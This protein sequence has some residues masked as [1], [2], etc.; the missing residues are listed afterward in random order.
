MRT[1][2]WV[3]AISV[4]SSTAHAQLEW[5]PETPGAPAIDT[6]LRAALRGGTE[7]VRGRARTVSDV[8]LL[9]TVG[10]AIGDAIVDPLS[11]DDPD[12]LAPSLFFGIGA[13]ALTWTLGELVKHATVRARPYTLACAETPFAC[14]ARAATLSFY[15]LHAALAAT[16]AAL[17]C[18]RRSALGDAWDTGLCI[19][20]IGSAAAVALLRIIGDMHHTTDVVVGALLGIASGLAFGAL[21]SSSDLR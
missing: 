13:L 7:D 21:V 11:H 18:A 17:V 14:D 20:S 19:G 8:L 1:A 5:E 10:V 12:A 3:I 6:T 2:V 16:S 4:L 9:A 15:S